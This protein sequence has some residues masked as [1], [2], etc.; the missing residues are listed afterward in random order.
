MESDSDL[1]QRIPAAFEGMSV[2]G[3]AGAYEFH[4]MS[5]DG[6]VADD[7][8]NSPAPAEVTVAVLS[9]EGDGTASDDLLLAVST[10]LNDETV[11]PV[12]DRLT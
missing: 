1:R 2:A 5:A 6:R 3:P 4:A 7:T 9:R 12:G 10:A 11:R 8:A